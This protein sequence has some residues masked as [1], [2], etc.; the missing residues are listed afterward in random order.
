MTIK[1]DFSGFREITVLTPPTYSKKMLVISTTF[2]IE[3]SQGESAI[4]QV[5]ALNSLHIDFKK[6]EFKKIK[7]FKN[8]EQ[9]RK[10]HKEYVDSRNYENCEESK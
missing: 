10:F 7:S 8:L 2:S 3:N 5:E 4:A 9:A 1:T 6:L